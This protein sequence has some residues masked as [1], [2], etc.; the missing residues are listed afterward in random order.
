MKRKSL[1]FFIIF[2]IFVLSSCGQGGVNL[3]PVPTDTLLPTHTLTPSPSP[4]LEPTEEPEVEQTIR[5]SFVGD[6]MFGMQNEFDL[7]DLFPQVYERSNS[8]T[9]PFDYVLDYFKS[10]DITVINYEGT[11][12]NH[13]KQADKP[14]RF[15][16]KP[17]YANI[18]KESSVEIALLANNHSY[19]YL[20]EGYIETRNALKSH[21]VEPLGHNEVYKVSVKDVEI[22][23]IAANFILVE[24]TNVMA[25][26]Y[27]DVLPLIRENKK[28][29]N[30]VIVN[31]HWGKEL[32][33]VPPKEQ[34]DVAH[35]YID[36]GAELIVGHHPHLLQGI[37]NYKGK[38]I[39]YSLGNFAFG[40]SRSA[41]NPDTI[42]YVH[43]WTVKGG[44]ILGD[45]SFAVPCYITSTDELNFKGV[46]A[47]NFRPIPLED[48]RKQACINL[49]LERS[50][51]L[52]HGIEAVS[53]L[54]LSL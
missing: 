22:V 35:L 5:I 51:P 43:E 45:D 13:T 28:E 33:K 11:L 18:L 7:P 4:T 44:K 47:N 52:E 48:E 1:I 42:I 34:R 30:I 39:V 49:I 46:L 2:L 3:T 31:L 38:Y 20:E 37:E 29:D 50:K 6:C 12:T 14:W 54:E 53:V 41:T 21:G 36:E 19:D 25:E 17:E 8:V 23:F 27:E 16:G 10:D 15:R 26:R 9:Y 32:E 40:G 24:D